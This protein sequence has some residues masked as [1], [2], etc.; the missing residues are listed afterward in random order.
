MRWMRRW[1]RVDLRDVRVDNRVVEMNQ[2]T[3][4]EGTSIIVGLRDPTK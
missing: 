1:G 3:G 4:R 2:R